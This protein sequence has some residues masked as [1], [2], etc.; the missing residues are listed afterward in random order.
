MS[1]IYH[2]KIVGDKSK[3]YEEFYSVYGKYPT[4]YELE[5]FK[6]NKTQRFSERVDIEE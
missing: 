6:K 2:K 4:F 5:Q 1:K 3:E